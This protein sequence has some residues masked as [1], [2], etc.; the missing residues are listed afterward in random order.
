MC[1]CN[2][3][4]VIL[5]QFQIPMVTTWNLWCQS[6]EQL[7]G[8]SL[9]WAYV[10]F[11]FPLFSTSSSSSFALLCFALLYV[12]HHQDWFYYGFKECL[13]IVFG[14]SVV[15]LM[16]V[17]C[18]RCYFLVFDCYFFSLEMMPL[19]RLRRDFCFERW[20]TTK[21]MAIYKLFVLVT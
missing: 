19:I 5:P 12:Y 14:G 1:I 21:I 10:S 13:K 3:T 18:F 15:R 16:W 7:N 6:D 8:P 4:S 9:E 20:L 2:T 17:K 11:L